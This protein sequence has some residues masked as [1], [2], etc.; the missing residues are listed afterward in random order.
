MSLLARTINCKVYDFY[1]LGYINHFINVMQ[2]CNFELFTTFLSFFVKLKLQ[3]LICLR[4]APII[5]PFLKTY[6]YLSSVYLS[7]TSLGLQSKGYLPDS[8][9]LLSLFFSL[10]NLM[11]MTS[12][13]MV[14]RLLFCSGVL[15]DIG[16]FCCKK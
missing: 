9:G 6:C 8:S 10:R 12:F 4:V 5:R 7:V 13:L 2:S 14:G 11:G 16:P 3:F 1:D 15:S